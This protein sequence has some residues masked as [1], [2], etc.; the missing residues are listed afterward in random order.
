MFQD[1]AVYALRSA[2]SYDCGPA[3]SPRSMTTVLP[4]RSTTATVTRWFCFSAAS[5]AARAA[6]VAG[7]AAVPPP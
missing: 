4:L 5:F 6:R 2:D 7:A 3:P 1:T